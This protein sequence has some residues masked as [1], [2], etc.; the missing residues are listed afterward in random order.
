[1]IGTEV[2]GHVVRGIGSEG[3]QNGGTGGEFR[4]IQRN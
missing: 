3:M 1:M 4:R 2:H